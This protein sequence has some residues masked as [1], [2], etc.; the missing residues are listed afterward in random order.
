M[1][2]AFGGE[3]AGLEV[4]DLRRMHFALGRRG[5]IDRPVAEAGQL[6]FWLG[7]G[8]LVC[9]SWSRAS[10]T[11][12]SFTNQMATRAGVS[13]GLATIDL[14]IDRALHRCSGSN[15]VRSRSSRNPSAACPRSRS[16]R[17]ACCRTRNA[18]S[19]VWATRSATCWR[20]TNRPDVSL[21]SNRTRSSLP[22]RFQ[23][24]IRHEC[25]Q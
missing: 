3:Q 12:L 14:R 16:S 20:D 11:D 19:A 10:Q 2:V 15:E 7:R 1:L 21:A 13:V 18:R 23:I 8:R 25:P 17:E 24:P 4:G 22:F 9:S 6:S 5:V